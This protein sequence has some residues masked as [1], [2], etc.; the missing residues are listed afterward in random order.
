[1]NEGLPEKLFTYTVKTKRQ[2]ETLEIDD[3]Q[4]NRN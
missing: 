1:M 3:A 2:V 4:D